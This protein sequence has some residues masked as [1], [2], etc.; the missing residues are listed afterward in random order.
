LFGFG[1]SF[2]AVT[3]RAALRNVLN[4]TATINHDGNVLDCDP[5]IVRQD[6]CVVAPSASD[7]TLNY[8]VEVLHGYARPHQT[9]PPLRS[10]KN[11]FV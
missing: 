1:A 3:Q 6:D 4:S 11:G 8:R 7:A 2:G 9:H 5:T 10:I